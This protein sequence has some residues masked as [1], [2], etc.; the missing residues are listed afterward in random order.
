MTLAGRVQIPTRHDI[1]KSSTHFRNNRS[2]GRL[3]SWRQ[4]QAENDEKSMQATCPYCEVRF[5]KRRRDQKFCKAGCRSLFGQRKTRAQNAV[6]SHN[7]ASKRRANLELFERMIFYTELYHKTDTCEQLGFLSE[8]VNAARAGDT[9]LRA[10]LINPYFVEAKN[11]DARKRLRSYRM[12]HS[13][14][15][16]V[17]LYCRHFWNA[18]SYDVILGVVPEPDT[19]VISEDDLEMARESA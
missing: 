17:D 6:N 18:S 9:K 3:L 11:N 14:G 19:G 13:I 7:S 10:V 4:S 16:I 5:T 8:L 15:K 1:V 2:P 12:A